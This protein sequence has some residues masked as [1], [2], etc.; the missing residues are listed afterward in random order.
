MGKKKSKK[1]NFR[2]FG[3]LLVPVFLL[4]LAAGVWKVWSEIKVSK[5]AEFER[6]NIVV[7][8]RT[9]EIVLLVSLDKLGKTAE[10]IELPP[11][12]YVDVPYGYGKYQIGAV[13]G[14]GELDKK[15]GL[16]IKA[17]VQ[18]FIGVPVDGYLRTGGVR[19]VGDVRE[20]LNIQL[21]E[22]LIKG[23]VDTDLSAIDIGKLVITAGSLRFDKVKF[24]QLDKLGILEELVLADGSKAKTVDLA[25]ID[26]YLN[27]N[28][29][30]NTIVS[31]NLKGEV[32]NSGEEIGLGTKA[33]RVLTNLGVDVV[34]V[35]NDQGDQGDR[36][37]KVRT[38]KE[39]FKKLTVL[40]VAG[41]FGCKITEGQSDRADFSLIIPALHPG[42]WQ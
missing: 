38:A 20:I 16:L 6:Y 36:D 34:N 5:L 22:N 17:T 14:L 19:G 26:Y 2:G 15:G 13:W 27:G 10:L 41:T 28:L 25:R 32:L 7:T 3:V 23:G 1:G 33:A 42:G 30:E 37:C 39:N 35:G 40:R 21:L 4:L 31:E 9:N 8:S 18:D 24:F 12:L 11:D 29:Q